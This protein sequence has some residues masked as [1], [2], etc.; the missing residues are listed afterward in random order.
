MPTH[1]IAELNAQPPANNITLML[2]LEAIPQSYVI[3]TVPP[4]MPISPVK[5]GFG[6][7]L[8]SAIPG[9][10]SGPSKATNT[11]KV[12]PHCGADALSDVDGVAV[13]EKPKRSVLA[14]NNDFTGRN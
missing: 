12:H 5:M 8:K 6:A 13:R 3:P 2:Q 1:I 11:M 7:M 10:A 4:T 14:V 9:A